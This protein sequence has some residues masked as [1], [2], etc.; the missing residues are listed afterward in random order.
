MDCFLGTRTGNSRPGSLRTISGIGSFEHDIQVAKK[1]FNQLVRNIYERSESE[2][3]MFEL[4]DFGKETVLELE[5][6][7][8]VGIYI[9]MYLPQSV[10]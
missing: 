2:M 3:E 9:C 7:K 6:F 8:E 10:Q 1:V 5:V 4:F